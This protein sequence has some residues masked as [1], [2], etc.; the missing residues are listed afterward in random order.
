MKHVIRNIEI[1]SIRAMWEITLFK[2][3]LSYTDD[4]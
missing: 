4:I 1:Y 3:Y 2:S